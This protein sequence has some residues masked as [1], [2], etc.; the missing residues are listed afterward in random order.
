MT[1]IFIILLLFLILF[2]FCALKV[3]SYVDE[4]IENIEN[5]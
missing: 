2:I 1:I 5:N 4:T 3:A